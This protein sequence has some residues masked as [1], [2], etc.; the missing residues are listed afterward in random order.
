MKRLIFLIILFLSTLVGVAV[1]EAKTESQPDPVHTV[2]ETILSYFHPVEG[3]IR[4]MED[5]YARVG[6]ESEVALKKGTRLSVFRE[7]KLFYHPVTKEPLGRSEDFVGRVEV[8]DIENGLYICSRIKGDVRKGD[9]VRITSSSVKLA[10]FQ[11]RNS[12]WALSEALYNSLKD[13]TRF[14][15]LEAYTK[16]YEPERLSELARELGAEVVLVLSTPSKTGERFLNV[17]LYWAEDAKLFAEVENAVSTEFTES[18]MPEKGL[19]AFGLKDTE[20]W[21]SYDIETGELIAVGDV[22]GNGLKELVV[23][24]GANIKI[25]SLEEEPREIW[26]IKGR[27]YE[28]HLSID[29]LDLNKNGR[30]EIFITSITGMEGTLTLDESSF[31]SSST[32]N[33]NSF[34]IEYHPEEGYK[35][36]KEGLSYFLRVMKDR[37]FMQKFGVNEIFSGPVYEGRWK[38]GEYVPHKSLTLPEGV[39]IYGF[40]FIDWKNSG[41]AQVISFDVEGYLNLYKDGELVWRSKRSYGK[42][43]LTFERTTHSLANPLK[44]WGIQGRLIPVR[45]EKGQEV[46]VVRKVPILSNV[47]GLGFSSAEVYSLW[48][49]GDIME[50]DLIIEGLQG[51]ITDYCL[52]GKELFLIARGGLFTFLKKAVTGDFSRGS[53]LYYY[54]FTEK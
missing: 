2:K 48:W 12:D 4:G 45:T 54:K 9:L 10:F 11:D 43:Y 23:S 15:I 35:R 21:G 49:D 6:F 24:D 17:K 25:Y 29:V 28:K 39:D 36:V 47:P 5:G 26:F 42:F 38:D 30:E 46:I 34:V 7:G 16:S 20:P 19:L 51:T 8:V 53:K 44:K 13:S 31:K 1:S 52:E 41:N 27:P 3:V 33:I 32:G 18:L 22:D 37:L 40:T 50:E 14:E